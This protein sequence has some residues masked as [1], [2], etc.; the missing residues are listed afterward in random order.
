[1]RT[2]R[3]WR[4]VLRPRAGRRLPRELRA[5]SVART[6]AGLTEGLR[7]SEFERLL[8]RI[9]QSPIL[10]QNEVQVFFKGEATF[11]A[12][13]QDIGGAREE[14]LVE[15]YIFKDDGTGRKFL[16][17]L[18][19]AAARGVAVRVLTDAI[20]S[21]ETKAGFW[22]EMEARGIDARLFHPLSA[23]FWNQLF[24]DHR[25]ILV[26]DRKTGYTGGM[27]IGDEYGSPR[28]KKGK[29]VYRD[30]HSRVRGPAAWEMATVFCEAWTRAGGEPFQLT[31]LEPPAPG[32]TRV[33]VLDS[34][35]GR[36]HAESASVLAAIAGGVRRRLWITNGYFAP[37]AR[38]IRLLLDT[39]GRGV[40]V[41]LLLPGLSDVPLVRHAAHGY[42]SELLP[43]VK[44]F[45]YQGAVLHAKT[46]V[47]DDLV[48]VVGSTNLDFRSFR[49]NA[50]C[51][52]VIFDEP[53]AKALAAAFEADLR[54]SREITPEARASRGFL[55]RTADALARKLNFLL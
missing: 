27:N 51:N 19:A 38:A 26:V 11:D 40:D 36:G 28:R 6:A 46:L 13:L 4:P 30:T 14:V 45:E 3:R 12:M 35:P 39:A 22:R 55:H 52:L 24:R 32:G 25:K 18:A 54:G 5:E 20:G 48:S 1:M 50:E 21:F 10:P 42:Y 44:I 33:L 9:E 37:R 8:S 53:A 43:H 29:R 47:A 15:S 17:A 23:R 16:E 49:F 7:D 34:R 41:R 2:R 31:S